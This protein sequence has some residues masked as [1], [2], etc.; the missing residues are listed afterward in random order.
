MNCQCV[1]SSAEGAL[2]PLAGHGCVRSELHCSFRIKEGLSALIRGRAAE[3][4]G[5]A[6]A[7]AALEQA[8]TYKWPA[9]N[10]TAEQQANNIKCGCLHATLITK[11]HAAQMQK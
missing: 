3:Q 7:V 2:V 4:L 6:L 1:L 5:Q 10:G 11:A 9:G 8:R